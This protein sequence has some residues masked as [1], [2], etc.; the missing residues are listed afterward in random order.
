MAVIRLALLAGFSACA[1]AAPVARWEIARA[2]QQV[3]S[4]AFHGADYADMV[5]KCVGR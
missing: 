2:T 4:A 5:S 3:P 1:L